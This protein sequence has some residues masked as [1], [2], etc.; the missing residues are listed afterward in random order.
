MNALTSDLSRL[1]TQR[2]AGRGGIAVAADSRGT[3]LERLFQEG[4][5]KLRL[6][7]RDGGGLEAVLINT[8][9]GLT[10]G[11]RLAWDIAVGEGAALTTTTQA[12]EKVYR[13]AG[14][15]A[16][17]TA[18]AQVGAGGRLAWLPQETILYQGSALRRR[19]DVTL[20]SDAR[21]LIVEAVVLGRK[22]H[23]ETVTRARFRESWRVHVEDRL[24][25]ADELALGPDIAAPT[26]N[27]AALGGATA[28]ATVL[29]VGGDEEHL[30]A[31]ARDICGDVGGASFWR[32]S[33][34][35]KL[36]ARLVAEDGYALRGRLV[37]LLR[38]LNGR[39]ELPKLWSS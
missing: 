36:L 38:L 17:A 13:S 18:T 15:E 11:D 39:A 9:G 6:P 12:S 22:A 8:A 33:G 21:A 5:A 28:F 16:Q 14:G 25:H 27:R 34:T 3:R 30:L 19:L 32:V 7:R 35:G 37:P 10:G 20:G 1:A 4:A 2:V 29:A 23:G 26:A 24:V 31:E